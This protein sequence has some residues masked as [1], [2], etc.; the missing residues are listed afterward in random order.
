MLIKLSRSIT[1]TL[2]F[3]RTQTHSQKRITWGYIYWDYLRIFDTLTGLMCS[4]SMAK[5]IGMGNVQ[6]A[7]NK[8]KTTEQKKDFPFSIWME[9]LMKISTDFWHHMSTTTS[10]F[11]SRIKNVHSISIEIITLN[12][13]KQQQQKKK[14]TK[15]PNK[16]N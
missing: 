6:F 12:E 3:A 15:N 4:F 1:C 14:P 5:L 8:I 11:H 10:L 9:K 13:K 2:T 16:A 7:E